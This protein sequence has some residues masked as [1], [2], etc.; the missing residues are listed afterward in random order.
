MEAPPAPKPPLQQS[1]QDAEILSQAFG[2]AFVGLAVIYSPKLNYT[3]ATKMSF[4]RNRLP[5]RSQSNR[6]LRE[7]IVEANATYKTDDFRLK[8]SDDVGL[9]L[10]VKD[11]EEN[12]PL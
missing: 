2:I 10:P 5:S 4:E 3:L 7:I 11:W 9:V 8:K 1:E 6:L 12:A